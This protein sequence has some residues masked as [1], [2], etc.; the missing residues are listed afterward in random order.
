MDV[1][2]KKKKEKYD[3]KQSHRDESPGITDFVAAIFFI[4]L[5]GQGAI[6]VPR[7]HL[8]S[9]NRGRENRPLPFSSSSPPPTGAPKKN[10]YVIG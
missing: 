2:K 6:V 5:W 4:S 7:C 3:S 9:K 10:P 1:K 8:G